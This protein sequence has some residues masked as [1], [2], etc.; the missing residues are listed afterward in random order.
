MSFVPYDKLHHFSIQ[1]IPFGVFS[2]GQSTKRVGTAIGDFV[3]DLAKLTEL[4]LLPIDNDVFNRPFLNDYMALGKP[5]WSRVRKRLQ[6]LL[7]KDNFELQHHPDKNQVLIPKAQVTMHLPARIG[8]YT[9]FYASKEHATN[10]GTMFRGK[11]NALMPNWTHLPVGYHGRASSVVV[12]DTP[13]TR[14]NGQRKG[15]TDPLPSFGPSL[16][17]D[18]ELEMAFF[19]GQGNDL[20]TPIPVAEVEDHI[21]GVVLM[22]DWSARDIQ[23]WEYVPLGPFLGKN[24]GTTV[25]PWVVQLEA[26]EPF[27]CQ[28]PDQDPK[29]LAYLN[30]KNDKTAYNVELTVDF[31]TKSNKQAT[32]ATSNLKYMYWTFAQQLAH[33]SVNGCNM[34]PGDLCGTGTISGPTESSFGSLLELTWNG[35]KNI[36]VEDE[37]RTFVEDGDSIILRG[38]CRGTDYSVGFGECTG[39]ILP[40]PKI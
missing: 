30:P 33:H 34:N 27:R 21:F 28:G 26:L 31:K 20:G 14:P 38:V 13:I 12:S 32:I 19:V 10:V 8:D 39:K 1:N 29:P 25:S 16:K 4:G 6:S 23:S 18:F 37:Q 5:V 11:D 22:N 40:A 15:K 9:D 3:V 35:T 17:L 24:F 36:S 2:V 7:S